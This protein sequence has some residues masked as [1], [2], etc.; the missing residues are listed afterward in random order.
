MKRLGTASYDHSLAESVQTQTSS[1]FSAR[2]G[3]TDAGDTTWALLWAISGARAGAEG[4]GPSYT[5]LL[6][7]FLLSQKLPAPLPGPRWGPSGSWAEA[8][9]QGR[10]PKAAGGR[11]GPLEQAD[12]GRSKYRTE[13]Q[14]AGAEEREMGPR[15]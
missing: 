7:S 6:P 3:Q 5:S 11:E 1:S 15:E 4:E 8:G 10:E 13:S 2:R 12:C 14:G 9:G